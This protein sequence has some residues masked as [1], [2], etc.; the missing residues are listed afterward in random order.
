VADVKPILLRPSRALADAMTKAAEANGW[1]RQEWMLEALKTEVTIQGF[2][3]S[4]EP[5]PDDATL[6]GV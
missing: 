1:S 2:P 5:H 3:P 6:P 4:V